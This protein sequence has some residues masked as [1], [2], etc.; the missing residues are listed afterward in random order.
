MTAKVPTRSNP[1]I[2]SSGGFFNPDCP[3][4]FHICDKTVWK[5]SQ[6]PLKK[7]AYYFADRTEELP[8]QIGY[9]KPATQLT[10]IKEYMGLLPPHLFDECIGALQYIDAGWRIIHVESR[11]NDIRRTVYIDTR[12]F[13]GLPVDYSPT[14]FGRAPI[15]DGKPNW[16]VMYST[17]CSMS[18][19]RHSCKKA[20]KMVFCYFINRAI[21]EQH[22]EV[23]TGPHA[24]YIKYIAGSVQYAAY[25][26]ESLTVKGLPES[27]VIF[28]YILT[29]ATFY[30][31][32]HLQSNDNSAIPRGFMFEHPRRYRC[33]DTFTKVN[34]A[35]VAKYFSMT[36]R[37]SIESL[38]P[39]DGFN[40]PVEEHLYTF[41]QCS[42]P[43]I[44]RDANVRFHDPHDIR[45]DIVST[46]AFVKTIEYIKTNIAECNPSR[47]FTA[48]HQLDKFE[49]K[50]IVSTQTAVNTTPTA[51]YNNFDEAIRAINS[52]HIPD[53]VKN[54]D[55]WF[56][57]SVVTGQDQNGSIF[58]LFLI[59]PD[60][61]IYNSY[62]ELIQSPD[63]EA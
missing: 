22:P 5:A 35:I 1:M 30:N 3:H 13:E 11:L 56:T 8:S 32:Y 12:D 40:G 33:I 4:K 49:L 16:G 20:H 61:T 19:F 60:G 52:V 15:T 17:F 31:A 2:P 57:V 7:I 54:S 43:G 25:V 38:F 18:N 53:T 34:D 37:P 10:H 44:L 26:L 27:V 21:E 63:Q 14:A 46:E 36:P 28:G 39:E 48:L 41:P 58:E 62:G 59:H 50:F 42:A 9:F 24:D 6:G 47:V 55:L 29:L 23:K 45:T 51:F